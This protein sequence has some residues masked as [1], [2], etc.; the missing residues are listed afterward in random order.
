M[1]KDLVVKIL[2]CSLHKISV[3]DTTTTMDFK[4]TQGLIDLF[5]TNGRT[6][7]NGMQK[8]FS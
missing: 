2:L 3:L 6:L 1:P 4:I 8:C 5:S 7:Y